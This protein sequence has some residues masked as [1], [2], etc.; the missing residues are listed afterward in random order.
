MYPRAIFST[1]RT[2]LLLVS[3]FPLLFVIL[4]S[5]MHIAAGN[6][7]FLSVSLEEVFGAFCLSRSWVGSRGFA[8]RESCRRFLLPH[9][10]SHCAPSISVQK[11]ALLLSPAGSRQGCQQRMLRAWH[12]EKQLCLEPAVTKHFPAVHSAAHGMFNDRV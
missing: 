4:I 9:D 1:Q 5:K 7:L 2:E 8:H 12:L 3:L 11:A 6:E 10:P